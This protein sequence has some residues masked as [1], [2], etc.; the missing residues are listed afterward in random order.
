MP[1]LLLI[2][3][4]GEPLDGLS[5]RIAS[6]APE[7]VLVE[8]TA[9]AQILG[10]VDRLRLQLAERKAI[11]RAKGILMKQ[12]GCSEEEAFAALRTLAM[13]RGLKLGEVAR[14]VIDVSSLLG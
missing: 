1:K 6:H 14:Q 5:E 7:Y 13:Q 8:A 12:R 2:E 3:C 9:L 4:A 11:E 10:E